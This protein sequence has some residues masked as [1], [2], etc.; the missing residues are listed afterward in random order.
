MKDWFIVLVGPSGSGKTTISDALSKQYG[1]KAIESYTTRAPRYDGER[2]HIFLSDAEFDAIEV[3]KV[4]A[5]TEFDGH[6]YCAT[7]DQVEDSDVYVVDFDGCETM[8]DL[9]H[10]SK[11]ILACYIE[12]SEKIR[13]NRLVNRDGVMTAKRRIENDCV[14]FDGQFQRLAGI[15]EYAIPICGADAPNE[16]ADAIMKC[17]E[18]LKEMVD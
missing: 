4:I 6:R 18:N 12:C 5:F 7:T 10:G 9:Y 13:F 8:Q 14:S 17:L 16:S 2:G 3:D 11:K 1:L 15:F